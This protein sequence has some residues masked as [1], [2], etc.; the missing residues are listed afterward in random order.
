MDKDDVC[1]ILSEIADLLEAGRDDSAGMVRDALSGPED[2]L[3]RFL[4]SNELWGGAGSIADQSFVSD[5]D[6]KRLYEL[7]DL[8]IRLGNLQIQMH[9]ANVRTA[10]WVAAFEQ[11][12]SARDN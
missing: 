4:V 11:W 10:S 8:L 7:E 1:K 6:P 9:K 3:E 12:R 2:A 5:N